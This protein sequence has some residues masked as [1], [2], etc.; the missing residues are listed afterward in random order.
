MFNRRVNVLG[1]AKLLTNQTNFNGIDV[2]TMRVSGGSRLVFYLDI[3]QIVGSLI[4]SITNAATEEQTFIEVHES[5]YMAT[6]QVRIPVTE[7]QRLVSISITCTNASYSLSVSA[8]DNSTSE[9]AEDLLTTISNNINGERGTF[10][11]RSGIATTTSTVIASTNL[12]RK[13]FYI[14]NNSTGII[15]F[16]FGVAAIVGQPSIELHPG[17]DREMKD[18]FISTESI[19]IIAQTATR[20]F[21]AKEG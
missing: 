6:T 5:T 4:F 17:D 9:E 20:T 12:N 14:Q 18:G 16:N 7:L 13:Y 1:S 19:N 3:T 15:W 11:D 2:Q 8:A 21:T 10:A